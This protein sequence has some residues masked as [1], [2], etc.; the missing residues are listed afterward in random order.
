[1]GVETYHR[2]WD[3]LDY[4]NMGG[5]MMVNPIDSRCQYAN[6]GFFSQLPAR[7]Y[8]PMEGECVGCASITPRCK[9]MRAAGLHRPLLPVP[10]HAPDRQQRQLRLWQCAS[11]RLHFRRSTELFAGVGT[12]GRIPDAEERYI[13]VTEHGRQC[14]R[15]QSAAARNPQHGDRRRLEREPA[16][17]FICGLE[18][19][20]SFL[21]NLH[22]GK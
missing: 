4:M 2:N 12:T 22:P 5:M 20:Y 10:R 9:S 11:Q 21:N 14:D 3:M 17:A 6:C 7:H 13:D 1:V 16:P 8:R 19:F 18:F 15:R